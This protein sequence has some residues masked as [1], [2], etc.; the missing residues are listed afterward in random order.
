[1]TKTEREILSRLLMGVRTALEGVLEMV[2]GVLQWINAEQAEEEVKPE[3][4]QMPR[5]L[6]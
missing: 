4:K 6:G 3:G 5:T 1:M 2:T